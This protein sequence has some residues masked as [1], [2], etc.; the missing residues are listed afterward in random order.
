[1]TQFRLV[2][3]ALTVVVVSLSSVGVASATSVSATLHA[4]F[5]PDRL[6]ASTTILFGFS[7][8]TSDGLAPPPLTAMDLKMPAGLGYSTTTLGLAVCTPAIIEAKG[9]A[10]CPTN[11]RLG[12]GSAVVEVP[13]GE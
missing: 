10:G 11:S 12:F 9:L 5:S 6:G 2:A 7:V 3:V 1:M 4:S 13:F 8:D